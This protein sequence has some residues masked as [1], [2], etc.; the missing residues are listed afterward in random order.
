MIV[1]LDTDKLGRF[2]HSQYDE[3]VEAAPSGHYVLFDDLKTNVDLPAF[4]EK[5]R[6]LVVANRPSGYDKF[7]SYMATSEIVEALRK[8]ELGE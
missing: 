4:I 7:S 8:M 3:W 1:I 6:S 5:M 2:S